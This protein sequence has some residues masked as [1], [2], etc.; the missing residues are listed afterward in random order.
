MY[1]ATIRTNPVYVNL[2]ELC[3]AGK[4]CEVRGTL[5]RLYRS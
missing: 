5:N 4:N 2:P 3:T 1:R